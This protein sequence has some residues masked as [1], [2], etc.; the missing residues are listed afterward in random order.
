M[1]YVSN[2]PFTFVDDDL[3]KVFAGFEVS[4]AYV[5]VRRNG[6]SKGFGFV[7]FASTDQQKKALDTFD[8]KELD[9]RTLTVRV[10]HK[11]DRRDEKGEL[12]EE[13]KTQEPRGEPRRR[14]NN[15]NKG[16]DK[17][18]GGAAASGAAAEKKPSE[19]TLY[20]SNLPFEFSDEDLKK[21]FDAHHPVNARIARR[22]NARSKGFGFVEFANKANQQAALALDGHKIADREISVKVSMVGEA[23]ANGDAPKADNKQEKKPRQQQ[24]KKQQAPKQPAAAAGRRRTAASPPCTSATLPLI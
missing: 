9:G 11:D 23:G 10:A 3:K 21:V 8:G 13:F 20:V 5:A 4:S 2:L 12:K 7:T 15:G 22:R 18:E 19:T 1:L 17:K 6:R 24:E 16:G 14:N